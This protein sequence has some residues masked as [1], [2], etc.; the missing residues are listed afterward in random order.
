MRTSLQVR[1]SARL[2]VS[3]E[4]MHLACDRHSALEPD[5]IPLLSLGG[6]HF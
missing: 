3:Y 5:H 2:L 4:H 1:P 6:M